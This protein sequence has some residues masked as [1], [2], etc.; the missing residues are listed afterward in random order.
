MGVARGSGDLAAFVREHCP[1]L[2]DNFAVP[3]GEPECIMTRYLDARKF[4]RYARDRWSA[5]MWRLHRWLY[6]RLT[7]RVD[8][9]I[10]RVLD[11]LRESGQEDN[12]L[13]VFTSDHGDLDDAH[14]VSN[15]LDL[16]PTLCDY[17]GARVPDGL[18]GKSLR[19]LAEGKRVDDWRDHVVVESQNG[20][21][22]R[23]DRLKCCVYDSGV[24]RETLV[25][26]H[27]DR[28]EMMNLASLSQYREELD[29]HRRL[30]LDFAERNGDE[31]GL[32][33]QRLASSGTL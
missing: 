25:D 24:N 31:V 26:L 8:A 13:I 1:P 30:L 9:Q 5:D 6:C 29:R 3:K 18:A 19:A 22:V 14:L 12:T 10:G 16:L 4:R 2:P 33:F 20:R 23:T 11:A 21:M 28:G 7:E 15:G 27:D 17:A 32:Q